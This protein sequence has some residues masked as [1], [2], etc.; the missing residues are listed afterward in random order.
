MQ[1]PWQARA[2]DFHPYLVKSVGALPAGLRGPVQAALPA[3]ARPAAICVFPQDYRPKGM[4]GSRIVP[5][6]ALIFI[7]DGVLSVQGAA[8]G[9][10]AP[11]PSYVQAGSV[12]YIRS[13]LLLNYGRLEIAAAERGRLAVQD[14]EFNA[15]G[16]RL[17]DGA[18]NDFING[19][20]GVSPPPPA[21]MGEWQEEATEQV[22]D[23]P[24]KFAN[25]LRTYGMQPGEQLLDSVFQ[26]AVW[27]R[28][29]GFWPQQ[30]VPR[31]L[32][33]LTDAA[34]VLVEEETAFVRKGNQYGWIVTQMPRSAVVAM[35]VQPAQEALQELTV[36][37]ARGG[38]RVERRILL[39]APTVE[40]WLA[41]WRAHAAHPELQPAAA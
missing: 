2:T 12:L 20:L 9:E 41:R 23:L 17:I 16:W 4:L 13:S 26:E 3:G 31:R 22:R 15:I 32:L 27:S 25:G 39:E 10:S 18:L 35:D 33:A 24:L 11:P 34:V 7:D 21:E 1:L 14:V 5:E 28:L 30:L 8:Q 29:G 38:A 40:A 19:A 6:Q 36:G 37:L